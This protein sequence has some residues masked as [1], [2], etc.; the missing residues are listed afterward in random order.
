MR[1]IL[2]PAATAALALMVSCKSKGFHDD[3]AQSA[4]V[5]GRSYAVDVERAWQA[6]QV[7]MKE[8]DLDVEKAE[9]D[10]LGGDVTARRSTGDGVFIRVRSV[11]PGTTQL[12][13]AVDPGDRNMAQMIQDRVAEKLGADRPGGG[14]GTAGTTMDGTYENSLDEC[15]AAAEQALKALKLTVDAREKHDIWMVLRSK[16]LDTIPVTIKLQR[17]PKDQTMASFSVG[18]SPSDDNQ[19]LAARLKKEFEAALGQAKP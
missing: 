14:G 1:N 3:P 12:D 8:L 15:A 2:V 10:A 9:H 13:V 6:V 5:A 11:N 7:T 4:D 18:T 17:T 16:H 19:L